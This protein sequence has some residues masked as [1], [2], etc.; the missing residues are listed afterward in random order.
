[1]VNA[2][3][4]VTAQCAHHPEKVY[5]GLKKLGFEHL[6][7]IPCLDP[8]NTPRGQMQ[9]SLAPEAYGDFL[10]LLFDLWYQD[11]EQGS[12]HS[13][14]LFDDYVHLLVGDGTSA[15][16]TCGRCGGYLVIE[17]DGSVYPCDFYVLDNWRLG[18][19][20]ETPL[21]EMIQG[22]RARSFYRWGMEKPLECANCQWNHFCDGGCKNDWVVDD[23]THNYFCIA[24]RQFFAYSEN[25]LLTIARAEKAARRHIHPDKIG[26]I[27]WTGHDRYLG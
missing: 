19:L 25:R 1:M 9:Y 20:G 18:R 21:K 24:F 23:G 8:M 3:C 6:Q 5:V 16:S 4:V 2:L 15:C 10:C 11:W 26:D 7:F 22:E 14:R 27:S 17:G 13:I 12:Y